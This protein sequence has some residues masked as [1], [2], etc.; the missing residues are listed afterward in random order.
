[1]RWFD[2]YLGLLGIVLGFGALVLALE[3]AGWPG[4]AVMIAL[5]VVAFATMLARASRTPKVVLVGGGPR[6]RLS[7][8][9]EALDAEGFAVRA[10][11]GPGTSPC[12]AWSGLPCPFRHDAVAAL[13]ATEPGYDGPSPPCGIA[14][15]VPTVTVEHAAS[16]PL[17]RSGS[18]AYVGATAGEDVAAHA[19]SEL[20]DHRD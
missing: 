16:Y 11:P 1:M 6:S 3:G 5:A 19:V 2:L 4:P 17:F 13:I 10:C 12:P 9:R 7:A 18:I 8:L 15:G 14:L 20:V